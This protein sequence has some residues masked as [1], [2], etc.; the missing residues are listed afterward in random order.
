MQIHI[1]PRNVPMTAGIHGY[2]AEKIG[3]L[4]HLNGRLLATHVVLWHDASRHKKEEYVV[5]V[6]LGLPGPDIHAESS[7]PD[8]FSAIDLVTDKLARQLRKYKTRI[9]KRRVTRARK[10][11][12]V[13]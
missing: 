11:K 10:L 12:L 8:L 5:K 6:H 9:L 4:E 13:R 2:V 3:H 7:A 1:S